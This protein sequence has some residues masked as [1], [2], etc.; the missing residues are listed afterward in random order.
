[1]KFTLSWL[2]DHLETS[3]TLTEIVETLT[4]IGLEVEHVHDPAAQLKNFIIAHVIDAKPHPNADRLRVCLVET[5]TGMPIQVVCGA[6][7]ARAGLKTVFS[8]PGTY[9]PAKK[10]TLGKGVIRGVESLGMLC[11]AAELELSNDHDGIIELPEDAPI[12]EIYAQWAGFDDPVI[13]INLTPNRPDAAGVFGIARDLAAAGIGVLK[14][15]PIQPNEDSFPCPTKISSTLSVADT[16]LAPLFGLRLIKG[17]TN[18]QSPRWL[19]DRLRAIGLRPIN[20]LVDITNFLTFDQARPLHVF[21]AKKIKGDLTIRLANKGE[22]LTALDG[23]TY[24]L[25]QTMVV[26]CDA[27]GIESIAGVMGGAATG[28]DDETTDVLLETALWDPQNIAQTGR[29]LGISSD[30]RYRFERGVDPAFAIPGA[31]LATQLILKY[32]G[33]E[34][35]HLTLL[36]SNPPANR[37]INFPWRETSRL[38]GVDTPIKHATT[39]LEGLGFQVRDNG[40]QAEITIPSWRPDVTSKADIVEEI[41][42]LSGVDN[43]P[44]TP[45]PRLEAITSATLTLLQKRARVSRRALATQGL[46]EAITWSFISKEQAKIFGG[47]AETLELA[48]PISAELSSMRPSLLPGLACAAQRNVARGLNE[49]ALFEVGQIF[50]DSSET[51]QR[52]AVAAIR[53]GLNGAGRH[54]RQ[55]TKRADVFDAKADVLSLLQSLGVSIAGLQIAPCS[56]P[57]F[58]PGRSATL[59]F[60]PKA[61]IGHFGEL[62]PR[63]LKTLDIEGDVSG[64]EIILNALPAP[65]IK[66]TKM[67]PKLEISDLQP[68]TRDFAFIVDQTAKAGDL[69]KAVASADRELITST[70]IFDVYDGTGVPAG[71]KSI[72]V[73]VTLQPR[74]KTLT[75]AEIETVAQKIITEAQRKTQATLR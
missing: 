2:K 35:S 46:A 30:A 70:T 8:A 32:C 22:T 37:V 11:S 29:K 75:D 20:C 6:P 40:M 42:R 72:G 67:K 64:F 28:C 23:K 18:G 55:N 36:G 17:V 5:G 34:A 73:A 58:H 50:L 25:D 31:E 61:I 59:Q 10:I 71:K 39:L 66:P 43:V 16:S 52:L 45:L 49:Q 63:A 56:V 60:G 9:I 13:E 7:N 12:G 38:T 14:T 65:K 62:H 74:E 3:A 26:I 24:E 33:G 1:M 27:T 57:W 51:G 21:D 4:R 19:Q 69:L 47:G 68:L 48:N 41:F 15:K 54:W 44:S 53:R